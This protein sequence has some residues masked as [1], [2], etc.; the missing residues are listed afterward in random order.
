MILLAPVYLWLL[1]STDRSALS[2]RSVVRLVPFVFAPLSLYLLLPL[3][4]ALDP[5][6]AYLR[7]GSIGDLLDLVLARTYQ[8]GIFRGGWAALPGRTKEFGGLLSRQFGPPGLALALLGWASLAW[9]R[10]RTAWVLM[11]GIAIQVVFALNYYVPNTYV[12][13]MPAYVW[14]AA[15]AGA[16]VDAVLGAI[17]GRSPVRGARKGRTASSLLAWPRLSPPALAHLELGWILIVAALP[18]WLA[19]SRWMGM[20]QRRAYANLSFDHTYGQGALRSVERDA[21]LVSDWR[22]ATVLWYAQL[23]E[24]HEPTARIAAVDSLEWQWSGL[25][26]GALAAGR[27]VYLARPLMS[28]GDRYPLSSAGPLVRVLDEPR[29]SAPSMAHSLNVDLGGEMRLLG[30]DWEVSGPGPEDQIRSSSSVEIQGGSTL[31]LTLYW[32]AL[33][34]PA[35][36]YAV[37][38][39]LVDASGHTW[40]QRQNRHPVGGTY[41]TSR[42]RRGEVVSDYYTFATPPSLPSGE[43]RLQA[44]IGVPFAGQ[45]LQD[46]AGSD[47]VSLATLTVRKPRQWPRSTPDNPV[48]RLLGR[49][50]VLMGYDAPRDAV[51]G[52]AVSV[53]VQWLLCGDPDSSAR[54]SLSL[55]RRDGRERTVTS[56][57]GSPEDW[58][59]G[60]LIVKQYTFV[61]PQD[62]AWIKVRADRPVIG[63][64]SWHRLRVRAGSA[65]PPVADFGNLIR[66]RSYAYAAASLRPGDTVRLTLEWEAIRAVSEPYKVF[67]HVLGRNGLPLAQQDNEPVNGTYPTTRWQSG[68]RISDRYTIPLPSDLPPGEY[69]VEVGLYR[70]SDL[71]RLPVLDAK[72]RAMDDKVFLA[73]LVIE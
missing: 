1:W 67:V 50:L 52:E 51:P 69:A 63:A 48:R 60:A 42:W 56:L 44:T 26:E 72:G 10:R 27:P 66:L 13:Y 15:C 70:I 7:I 9:R 8:S 37:A 6:Y 39:R 21:L 5:P 40:M 62:L 3:F 68:E 59:P 58:K 11:G 61:V 17:S 14:L 31:H 29:T 25:V 36:D 12:Y 45:G 54:P 4:S 16:A 38:V 71:G 35:G 73:P 53:A 57:P 65:P 22:P 33:R 47:R 2:P 30:Y 64:R 20:D 32:Q 18:V 41:P 23:V 55:V 19:V 34:A 24:G 43:Y 46:Q 49:G 28:A